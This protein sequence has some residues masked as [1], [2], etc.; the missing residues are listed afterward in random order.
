MRR[1]FKAWCE[2][3]AAEYRGDLGV[4]LDGPLDPRRL[5]VVLKVRVLT[6]RDFPA[7]SETS[8]RQLLEEDRYG[9]SA[10]TVSRNGARLVVINPSHSPARQTSNLAHE[11]AHVILDHAP[12]RISLS[13]E[14][15]LLRR[16]HD[17]DQ[18][19][20]AD[21]LAGCLL[22]PRAGLVRTYAR[23]RS[24]ERL[25]Q[26]FGVSIEL[27]RWRLESTGVTRQIRAA[28]GG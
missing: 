23:N 6:P 14:G 1:G 2:R 15:I 3:T 21:W 5:A 11:L 24:V 27:I 16:V 19:D 9:W 10:V 26:R 18:E 13:D 8:Q 7:L 12:E 28:R 22:A 20:E 17:P 25:A 4:P